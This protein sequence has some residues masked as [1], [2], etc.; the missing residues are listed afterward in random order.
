MNLIDDIARSDLWERF[1]EYRVSHY[2]SADF[3][4]DLRGFIDDRR[5]LKVLE[6][7]R[8]GYFPLPRRA[9]ISKMST[10]KKRVVYTYPH[11]ENM[12][13]KFL[14]YY[15]IRR[16]DH[17]FAPNLYSFRSQKTVKDAIRRLTGIP[18]ISSK[19]AY[20]VDISNY[21]NSIPADRLIPML[22]N[23]L[24]DDPAL[25]GFLKGLL[26]EPGVLDGDNVITEQKGIMAGTPIASFYADLYLNG[27]DHHFHDLGITYAR[28]SDDI[29]VFADSME[30]AKLHAEYI[31]SFLGESGLSVNPSKE[32]FYSPD[33]GW[34][35]LGFYY[36]LGVIDIAPASVTKIKAKMRRKMRALKRW[37]KR[38]DLSS[39]RSASAFIRVFN[40]KLF[41]KRDDND[42][43]W[44]LWYFPVINTTRSL[45]VI[46]HYAQDCVR[47]LLTDKHTKGRY[48][49]RYSDLKSLGY[50]CLVNEYYKDRD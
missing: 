36:R 23:V 14:T 6:G 11:D 44:S 12:V 37:E 4:S 26:T 42:L 24:S 1:Y 31:R 33:D 32:S 34:V 30:E 19:Y 41:E 46:D 25:L 20:K 5:Y 9:V 48:S 29:I 47:Y 50:K 35:F 17:I 16:Y 3:E 38:K 28:Y 13:L 7:I 22:E 27:L 45:E 10:Q 8:S 43:T 39:D 15:V 40:R 2:C 21:F 18:G 49:A